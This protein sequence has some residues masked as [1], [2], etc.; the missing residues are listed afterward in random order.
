MYRGAWQEWELQNVCL[1]V[2]IS[3]EELVVKKNAI[4]RHESQ[5]QAMFPGSDVR[6]FWQRALD[7]NRNTAENF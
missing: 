7:R 4:F 6:E 1:A 5:R 2:P 3:P